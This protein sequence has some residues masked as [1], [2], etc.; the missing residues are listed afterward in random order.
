MSKKWII[1]KHIFTTFLAIK[2][3]LESIWEGEA[4]WIDEDFAVLWFLETEKTLDA[5]CQ[6]IWS[7]WQTLQEDVGLQPLTTPENWANLN[8][9]LLDG[10]IFFQ[11]RY[12][13]VW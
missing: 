4:V 1:C 7:F 10:E 9:T 13:L 12:P 11:F 6:Q 2:S 8:L 3:T 5:N